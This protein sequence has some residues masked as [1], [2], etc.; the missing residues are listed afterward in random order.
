MKSNF[1]NA[2]IQFL[3]FKEEVCVLAKKKVG[4]TK[5]E[6]LRLWLEDHY[7]KG[8]LRSFNGW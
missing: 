8:N 1:A 6:S 2:L 7:T 3:K 4:M 5:Y